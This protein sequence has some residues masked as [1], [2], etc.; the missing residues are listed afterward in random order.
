MQA[1]VTVELEGKEPREYELAGELTGRE[2]RLVKKVSGLR[3]NEIPD[4]LVNGDHDLN[5]ALTLIA[6]HR[7]DEFDVTDDDLLALPFQSVTITWAS[8]GDGA[9]D[10][11]GEE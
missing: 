9:A 3:L 10:E 4:A 11:G 7:A 6:M 5:I 8:D 2:I 1:T